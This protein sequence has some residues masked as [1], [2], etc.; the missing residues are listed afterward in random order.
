M[1]HRVTETRTIEQANARFPG[2]CS[3]TRTN[4]HH[5]CMFFCRKAGHQG[6]IAKNTQRRELK[7]RRKLVVQICVPA[8]LVILCISALQGASLWNRPGRA[9]HLRSAFCSGGRAADWGKA[10]RVVDGSSR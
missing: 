8:R 1:V 5:P 9:K 10:V 3:F 2:S 4:S 6:V 7:P